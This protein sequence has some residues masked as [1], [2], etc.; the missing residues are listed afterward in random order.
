LSP[1]AE[2]PV[3]H[4]SLVPVVGLQALDKSSMDKNNTDGI[5]PTNPGPVILHPEQ[6][7]NPNHLDHLH[8]HNLAY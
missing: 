4:I 8:E 7:P 5:F 6:A 1:V 2:E 3:A